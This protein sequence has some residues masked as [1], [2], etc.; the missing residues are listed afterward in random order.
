M[1]QTEESH[2][3]HPGNHEFPGEIAGA[4]LKPLGRQPQDDE[5]PVQFPG[6]IAG[7]SLKPADLR[8]G[9]PPTAEFPGEIAGASLKRDELT[10]R[11]AGGGTIPR[12]NRR[13]LIEATGPT[14]PRPGPREEFPGEIA[15]ASLKR[16]DAARGSGRLRRQ[17]PGEIAGASLKPVQ[18]QPVGALRGGGIPRRNRRGLIEAPPG[19]GPGRGRHRIPRR[20]RRGLIEAPRP[21]G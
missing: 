17:F 7:A 19:W 14:R 8:A 2:E 1:K 16:R 11:V 21:C 20:N 18:E 9:E 13:G 4:S 5:A 12:R 10:V 3:R 15:G 6:E